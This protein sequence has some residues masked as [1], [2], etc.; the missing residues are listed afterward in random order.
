MDVGTLF[1][2]D[3]LVDFKG[4]F[5]DASEFGAEF[6]VIWPVVWGFSSDQPGILT[7]MKRFPLKEHG[8]P[9]TKQF[10][11][12][13]MRILAEYHSD[14]QFLRLMLLF[15]L[16]NLDGSSACHFAILDVEQ[17][18]SGYISKLVGWL[19]TGRSD[20]ITV[21]YVKFIQWS[22]RSE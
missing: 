20:F 4:F 8:S 12:W 21:E 16:V 10:E 5:Q 1:I 6:E 15:G 19:A 2:E 22:G 13:L 3:K 18:L 14:T 9:Y 17:V 7:L 11:E